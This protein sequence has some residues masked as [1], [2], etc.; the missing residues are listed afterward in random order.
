MEDSEVID[1]LTE[2]YQGVDEVHSKWYDKK[3]TSDQAMKEVEELVSKYYKY[4]SNAVY[5]V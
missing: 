3:I 4:Y 2:F 5:G 1:G